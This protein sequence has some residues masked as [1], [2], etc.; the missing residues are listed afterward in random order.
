MLFL[1]LNDN[2][3]RTFGSLILL[4]LLVLVDQEDHLTLHLKYGKDVQLN[5]DYQYIR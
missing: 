4:A 3:A 2:V 5:L 1:G